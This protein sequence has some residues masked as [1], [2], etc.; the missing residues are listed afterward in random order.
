MLQKSSSFLDK[1][2][3][4]PFL[5]CVKPAMVLDAAVQV[6]LDEDMTLRALGD[7]DKQGTPDSYFIGP[8]VQK[9]SLKGLNE[10]F[11][12]VAVDS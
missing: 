1:V 7:L 3:V 11:Q 8:S 12:H 10:S 2:M 5:S 9:V 4:E 6:E